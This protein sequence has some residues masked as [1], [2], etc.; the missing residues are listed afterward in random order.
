M[1]DGA[2]DLQ[3][4]LLP[5]SR[6]L[7]LAVHVGRD[8]EIVQAE[9]FDPPLKHAEPVMGLRRSVE[10][11]PV[12]VEPPAECRIGL[13]VPRIGRPHERHPEPL[14]HRVRLP[15]PLL[16][17]E[18]RQPGVHSHAGTGGDDQGLRS[19]D[20]IGRAP[21]CLGEIGPVFPHAT[22]SPFCRRYSLTWPI[23][24]IR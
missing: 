14:V 19:P 24:R 17:P 1:V 13:E 16:P 9:T 20:R 8:D 15:E 18:V 10:V 4:L 2:V 5:E 12:A 7:E 23:P 22:R 11:G 21:A 3:D 6:L